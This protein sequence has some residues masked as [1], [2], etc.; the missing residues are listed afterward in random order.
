MITEAAALKEKE[1]LN[2]TDEKG[3]EIETKSGKNERAD[4]PGLMMRTLR[5]MGGGW[6]TYA[7]QEVLWAGVSL[8]LL[9]MTVLGFD[10]ITVGT[11]E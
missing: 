8:A 10:A 1:M 5:V 7:R 9:Y 3:S 4:K 6:K 2:G 11:S